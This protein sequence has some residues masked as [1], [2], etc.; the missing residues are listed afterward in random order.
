MSVREEC[1]SAQSAWPGARAR[2]ATSLLGREAAAMVILELDACHQAPI[3]TESEDDR[4]RER[5]RELLNHTAD[6]ISCKFC[7][8]VKGVE[9]P[10]RSK[11]E[12]SV[13]DTHCRVTA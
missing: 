3:W 6:L 8:L 10:A 13:A 12:A 5:C 4:P 11:T 9:M 7:R 1:R 2:C